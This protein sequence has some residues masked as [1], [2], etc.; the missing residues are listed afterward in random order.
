MWNGQI[1]N[2][3]I[4][5]EEMRYE[6]MWNGEMW[7]GEMWNGEMEMSNGGDGHSTRKLKKKRK[8]RSNSEHTKC[9]FNT[10]ECDFYKLKWDVHTQSV[11]FA[12]I[13][14]FHTHSVLFTPIVV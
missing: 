12:P 4:W 8:K 3:E 9:V 11:I 6:K 7:N 10:H 14:W 13:M 2:V 1:R 5:S